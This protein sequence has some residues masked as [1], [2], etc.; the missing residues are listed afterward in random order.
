MTMLDHGYHHD[1]SAHHVS[2]LDPEP[3][4]RVTVF[5]RTPPSQRSGVHVRTVRDGE[6]H[7]TEAVLDRE[8]DGELWWRADLTAHNPVTPYRFLLSGPGA[9]SGGGSGY[10]WL[11]AAGLSGHDLPDDTD[12]R[13]STHPGPPAWAADAVVYEVFPDRFD[14]GRTDR[15]GAGPRPDWAVPCD[16]DD[17]VIGRGPETPHQLYG[18][19]LDG[20]RARLD[21]IASLGADTLWLTP[22]FPARSNHRYNASAFDRTD[23]LLG[24][25]AAYRALIDAVHERGWRILGDLTTNHCGDD[26]PWF[27]AARADQDSPERGMFWFAD[28]GGTGDG[29]GYEAWMGVPSLPKLDWGSPALRRRMTDDPDAVVTRWLDF[30]LDGWRIDVAN[31]TG[32]RGT[33]D[34]TRATAARILRAMRR[35]HPQSLLIAEHAHDAS[36]DLDAGGWHGTM[37]YAGFTRPVWSWLRGPDTALE[38]LGLPVDVPRL[39]GELAAAAMRAFAARTSWRTLAHSW[40]ILGSHDTARI[41]T[42]C[43]SAELAEV[44]C[45][46]MFTLPGTPVVYAGDEIGLRGSWGE[47]GRRPMPWHRPAD[48][49]LRTLAVH[50][51]LAAL[52][53]ARP[54][55]S[56]GGLRMLHAG[57]DSL[58]YLRELGTERLLVHAARAAHPPVRLPL[59][60]GADPLYGGADPLP[61]TPGTPVE[62]PSDGPAFHVW[63][64]R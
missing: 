3:G 25:D 51:A 4:E 54:A 31:M 42:V 28:G 11:T 36:G 22:V 62:L 58:T 37:N 19:D 26:H 35:E 50:R 55:L 9:G 43:G 44:A 27:T 18:G 34:L 57:A 12:F 53:R 49:D 7:F 41:R 46:L 38:F 33:A 56:R 63:R 13:L 47:D 17:P 40:S 48:W 61:G 23:P 64:L 52:R 21:H 60:A 29:P 45:G 8:A 6:P 59:P 1:G 24:G 5:L 15:D 20:V 14:R 2:T 39:P 32:R 16:W 30:G 10:R